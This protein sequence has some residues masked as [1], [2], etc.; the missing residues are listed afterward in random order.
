LWRE[1]LRGTRLAAEIGGGGSQDG[2]RRRIDA[3][4]RYVPL[5]NLALSPQCGF[6]STSAGNV[7]TPDQQR[8]KL[9]LIVD[10]ADKVWGR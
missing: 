6:A 7:L 5:E 9:A 10:T 2:L 4:A 3:A 1:G 8:A